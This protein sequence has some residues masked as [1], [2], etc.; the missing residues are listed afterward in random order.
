MFVEVVNLNNN[1]K[2]F[3]QELRWK[4]RINMKTMASHLGIHMSYL[5]VVECG[6]RRIPTEWEEKIRSRYN[7][8]K[9]ESE[10]LERIFIFDKL[11]KSVVKSIKVLAEHKQNKALKLLIA[12]FLPNTKNLFTVKTVIEMANLYDC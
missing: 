4:E 9:E 2:V 12:E 8:T 3:T 11:D 10:R 6:K 1:F 7:L 5:S